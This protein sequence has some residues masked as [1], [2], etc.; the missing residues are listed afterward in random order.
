MTMLLREVFC[1]LH[2]SESRI[3][4]RCD[5]G[6][7]ITL[8]LYSPFCGLKRFSGIVITKQGKGDFSLGYAFAILRVTLAI[9]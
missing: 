7:W 2:S 8:C 6:I 1:G 3:G 4:I 9:H 5:D